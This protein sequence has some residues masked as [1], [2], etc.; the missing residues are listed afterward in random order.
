MK[1]RNDLTAE[2]VRSILNYDPET[3]LFTWRINKGK[4]GMRGDVAGYEIGTKYIQI[5]INNKAYQAHRLAWLYMTGKWPKEF[6]DHI[7][8]V[9]NDNRFCNLREATRI[10]NS[11]NRSVQE[12][13]KLGIKG[14][15]WDKQYKKYLSYIY[16]RENNKKKRIFLGR[17]DSLEDAEKA[18][19]EGEF[20]YFGPFSFYR[21][22]I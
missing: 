21:E 11:R 13:N 15:F 16:I 2:F 1:Y 9:R 6:L 20:K 10:E 22:I 7:N 12:N 5:K 14:I 8:G 18:R 19:I 4:R 17:Y 3:G